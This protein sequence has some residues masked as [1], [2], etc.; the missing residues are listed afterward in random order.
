METI[1]QMHNQ[2]H[3]QLT[4]RIMRATGENRHIY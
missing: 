1:L 3:G 4:R 2:I